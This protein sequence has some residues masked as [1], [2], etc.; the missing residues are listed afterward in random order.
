M[1]GV[2]WSQIRKRIWRNQ[3]RLAK[4]SKTVSPSSR[5]GTVAWSNS[6]REAG[7]S[8]VRQ[9]TVCS[10][11]PSVSWNAG[12][13]HSRH[14]AKGS[15]SGRPRSRRRIESIG[16]ANCC[17][18]LGDKATR[19][20]SAS[21]DLQADCRGVWGQP[22]VDSEDSE[23]RGLEAGECMMAWGSRNSGSRNSPNGPTH[24]RGAVPPKWL[25]CD[26]CGSKAPGF[27]VSSRRRLCGLCLD[28]ELKELRAKQKAR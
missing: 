24:E 8:Q 4:P 1:L 11:G 13:Q 16:Q 14:D 15:S 21:H 19:T 2:A 27:W 12:R 10:T 9:P 3:S 7:L 5:M 6:I 28:K 26:K 20:S 17:R 25:K 23:R 22:S 18:G